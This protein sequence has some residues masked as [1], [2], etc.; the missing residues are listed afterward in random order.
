MVL[1]DDRLGEDAS[2]VDFEEVLS[3]KRMKRQAFENLN[4]FFLLF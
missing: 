2:M 3:T 1:S 4:I